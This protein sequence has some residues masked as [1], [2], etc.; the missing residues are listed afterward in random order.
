MPCLFP[1]WISNCASVWVRPREVCLSEAL[2]G[3]PG[4]GTRE[5]PGQRSRGRI[6]ERTESCLASWAG[7]STE[8]KA[9]PFRYSQLLSSRF[10]IQDLRHLLTLGVCLATRESH[11]PSIS[12]LPP[13]TG[14]DLEAR[15]STHRGPVCFMTT[16]AV[17]PDC[18]DTDWHSDISLKVTHRSFHGRPLRV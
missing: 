16:A 3:I 18:S 15:K 6:L 4:S 13:A 8:G 14:Q 2:L 12:H 10:L 9:S 1:F 7:L 17:F 11:S 5:L